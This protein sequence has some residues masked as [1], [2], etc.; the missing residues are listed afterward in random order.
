MAEKKQDFDL[1]ALSLDQDKRV[2]PENPRQ[3]AKPAA[4][5]A[6][7]PKGKKAEKP[8]A[9]PAAGE[10]GVAAEIR[11]G[12]PTYKA[13]GTECVRMVFV[14]PVETKQ[15]LKQALAGPFFGKYQSQVE[16][17]DAAIRA[18]VAGGAK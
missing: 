10:G 15:M 6:E 5:K 2:L 13:S 17:V 14:L 9:K 3:Q 8:A 11:S 12:R 4:Q 1:S 7:K 16:I 18:F